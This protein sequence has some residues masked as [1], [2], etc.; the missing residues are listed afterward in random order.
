[1][2]I[3]ELPALC[4][5]ALCPSFRRISSIAIAVNGLAI[6][7]DPILKSMSFS[8]SNTKNEFANVYSDQLPLLPTE[9]NPTLLPISYLECSSSSLAATIV[10]A[11]SIPPA[12]GN[13]LPGYNPLII[14]RSA[15]FNGD[16]STFI[17]TSFTFGTGTGIYSTLIGSPSRYSTIAFIVCGKVVSII[18][19]T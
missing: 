15:G 1:M 9:K 8:N 13:S 17:N 11:P 4:I 16:A 12:T 14:E 2:P 18:L 19:Y 6:L 10:P 7:H 3:A 5:T